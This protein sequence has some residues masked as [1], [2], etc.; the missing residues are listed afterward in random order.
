VVLCGVVWCVLFCQLPICFVNATDSCRWIL[1]SVFATQVFILLYCESYCVVSH[2][3]ISYR[4]VLVVSCV[5]SCA[6]VSYIDCCR[7]LI[8]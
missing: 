2:C 7:V 4:I 8:Q 1:K 5:V 3:I 6:G